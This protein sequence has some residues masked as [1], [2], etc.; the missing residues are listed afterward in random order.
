MAAH[1]E[2][3]SSPQTGEG[4]SFSIEHTT[5]KGRIGILFR[6]ALSFGGP[7]ADRTLP[8]AYILVGSTVTEAR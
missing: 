8:A 7:T 3:N 1:T 4:G 2:T 6:G 5:A